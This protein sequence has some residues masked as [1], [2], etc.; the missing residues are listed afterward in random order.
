MGRCI[1]LIKV[2]GILS[3][4]AVSSV[5]SL[6][7]FYGVSQL[8]ELVQYDQTTFAGKFQKL[9]NVTRVALCGFGS[10]SSWLF[11]TAFTKSASRGKHPYL[12]YAALGFPVTLLAYALTAVPREQN[13]LRIKFSPQ[14]PSKQK[15]QEVSPLDDSVY[16]EVRSEEEDAAGAVE[17]EVELSIKRN[18]ARN[19]MEGLKNGYSVASAISWIAFAI[20]AV[21]ITG[22][23][24]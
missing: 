8:Q 17:H 20:A 14:K 18:E 21:G 1:T 16:G 5:L 3:L 12:V 11:F 24:Y 15:T 10:L 4:G 22:D 6:S 9:V 7:A 23:K 19:N 2:G 13:T